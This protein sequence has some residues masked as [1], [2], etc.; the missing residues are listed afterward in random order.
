MPRHVWRAIAGLLVGGICVSC[1]S[2]GS[3]GGIWRGPVEIATAGSP[4]LFAKD[5]G[6]VGVEL[7]LGEYGPELSGVVRFYRNGNFVRARSASPPDLECACGFAHDGKV[8]GDRAAFT[9]LG[10]LPGGSPSTAIRTRAT[11]QTTLQGA[12]LELTVDDP[13]SPLDGLS[14]SLLLQRQ[15]LASDI[16]DAD[17]ACAPPPA[18]GNAASG[19]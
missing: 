4:L 9:L 16:S 12:Q 18:G 5:G 7:V 15:G 17:L 14:T 19:R 1:A 2:S 13:T 6:A 11:L 3:F 8:S 10:C